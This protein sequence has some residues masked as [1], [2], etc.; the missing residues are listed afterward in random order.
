M[1]FIYFA[2]FKDLGSIPW[3]TKG[4]FLSVCLSTCG[5]PPGIQ[6]SSTSGLGSSGYA[7]LLIG[8]KCRLCVCV[9]PAIGQQRCRLSGV[10]LLCDL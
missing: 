1:L 9:S 5:L 2:H 8:I 4:V 3:L 10:K 6:V 7:K